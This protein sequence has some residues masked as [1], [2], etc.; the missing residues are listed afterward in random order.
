MATRICRISK[1]VRPQ[2]GGIENH[3]YFLSLCQQQMNHDITLV[4]PRV[5]KSLLDNEI[6]V[7]RVSS[8]VLTPMAGKNLPSRFAE[9]IKIILFAMSV[10]VFCLKSVKRNPY[11]I[12][13]AHGDRSMA[14]VVWFVSRIIRRKSI[15]T[16]HSGLDNSLDSFF[17]FIYTLPDV[18]IGVSDKI[19]DQLRE[20]TGREERIFSVSSGVMPE[21]YQ[22]DEPKYQS[23]T[24]VCFVGRLRPSKGVRYLV[25]AIDI[26]R[27]SNP[28]I[29]ADII[30]YGIALES[31][32]NLVKERGMENHI[33]FHTDLETEAVIRIL[34][35]SAV[36]V[37]P[38]ITISSDSTEG[39]PTAIMEALSL[40]I[41]VIGT[42]VG[43]IPELIEEEKN[44]LIVNE[45]DERALAAAISRILDDESLQKE[46]RK[47]AFR[48]SRNFSWPSITRRVL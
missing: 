8:F 29:H 18:L 33:S 12:I 23:S 38:S 43:G 21:F 46:M 16:V 39:R 40:G 20:M 4:V 35:Q 41:P 15:L 5:P 37:M 7:H 44:G 10:L 1:R 19:R 2:L 24:K 14:F 26:V 22:H 45:K 36:F 42:N 27:R 28:N 47:N 9:T 25:G 32:R 31:L 30:G 3:V 11:Q 13:H 34:K 48:S 17:N 6:R